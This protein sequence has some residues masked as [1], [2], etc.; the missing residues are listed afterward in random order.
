MMIIKSFLFLFSFMCFDRVRQHFTLIITSE[1]SGVE[2]SPLKFQDFLW[3]KKDWEDFVDRGE[4]MTVFLWS[5]QCHANKSTKINKPLHKKMK[6][7]DVI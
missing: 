3:Y 5:W 2:V 6:G 1:G 4:T 7:L